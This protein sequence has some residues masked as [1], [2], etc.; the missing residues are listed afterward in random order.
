M[1]GKKFDIGIVGLGV[2]GSNLAL[3][4]ADHNFSVAAYNRDAAKAQEFLK[5]AAGRDVLVC[6]SLAEL[7]ASLREPR[8][9]M[10]MVTAGAAVKA[11]AEGLALHLKSGD[12]IVDGGNSFYKDTELRQQFLAGKGIH[13]IGCGV[14]GGEEG[15]RLGPSLMPG[16]ARDGYERVRPIFEAIAAKVGKDPCVA[17]L[18]RGSA[19]HFVKMVHNGIEYGVM[20]LIAETYD[21]MARGLEMRNSDIARVFEQWNKKEHNSYLI[22]IT[23][24]VL[25]YV[26]KKTGD[27][28]VNLILDVARQKGTGIWTSVSALE[29][30]CPVPTIDAAV[31]MRHISVW[32]NERD[33]ASRQLKWPHH[34][35]GER[36]PFIAQLGNALYAATLITYAQGMTLLAT[37]SRAYKYELNLAEVARIWRG[38]CI[39]RAAL[40]EKIRVAYKARPD[41]HSL[42]MD[43]QLSTELLARQ[44]HFR[45]VVGKIAHLGIPASAF[46]ASLSYFDA[47]RAARLPANLI[48][49]Q[50]DF[51]GAHTYERIDEKG[52]F[53][54]KWE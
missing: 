31:A 2:M 17:Y 48:Q 46:A 11:V 22:E 43:P 40:L 27:W 44:S 7:T 52:T 8:L 13:F 14:S 39:I 3:N 53:H 47:Y 20:Q 9:V 32:K 49:A 36:E 21:L 16:G 50:R 34:F 24:K 42:L 30:Q 4:I 18:G 1:S 38:G 19:G 51:F 45:N 41:L 28:L 25:N 10:L 6:A 5:A 35:R 37:A 29:L 15:A 23:A 33:L 26:D 12:V 54:T